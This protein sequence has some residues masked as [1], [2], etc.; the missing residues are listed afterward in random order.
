MEY[1]WVELLIFF[2]NIY[3]AMKRQRI[4]KYLVLVLF[5]LFNYAAIGQGGIQ[6]KRQLSDK[7]FFGGGLGMQFGS[8]TAI[9][10][11]PIVGYTPV[12]NLYFGLKGKYEYYKYSNYN[13]GTSIY[14]GSLFGMYSFFEAVAVYAEYEVLSLESLYFDPLQMQGHGDRFWLQSPLVGGGYI[15]SLGGRSKLMLMILW[16]LNET[17]GTYYSNPIIRVS[18][19]F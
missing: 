4:V 5:V 14:G 16:N 17:Y 19:L 7:I 2:S 6:K 10:I 9:N 13:T 18:F 12:D 11:S 8:V 1:F 15:Q 3:F